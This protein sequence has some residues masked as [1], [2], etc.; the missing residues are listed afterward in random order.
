LNETEGAR[1]WGLI[2][3]DLKRRGVKEVFFFCVDG[4]CLKKCV[5]VTNKKNNNF[6]NEKEKRSTTKYRRTHTG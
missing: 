4:G 3:E 2:L 5:K 1:Q 6:D